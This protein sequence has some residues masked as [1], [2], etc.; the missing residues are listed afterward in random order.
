MD[1]IDAL[2]GHIQV[3]VRLIAYVAL[4]EHIQLKEIVP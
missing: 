1:V 3:Q 2:Q 4:L